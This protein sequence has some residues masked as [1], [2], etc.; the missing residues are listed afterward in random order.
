MVAMTNTDI[1]FMH[2]SD[3]RCRNCKNWY[4]FYPQKESGNCMCN[5]GPWKPDEYCSKWEKREEG[6]QEPTK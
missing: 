4:R 6:E 2:K 1:T 5:S 3:K